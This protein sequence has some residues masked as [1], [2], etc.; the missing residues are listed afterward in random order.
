MDKRFD[1]AQMFLDFQQEAVN[2]FLT[3]IAAYDEQVAPAMEHQGYKLH[4]QDKRTVVF[5]FGEVTYYRNRWSKDGNYR[6]PVDEYLGLEKY[7]RYSNQLVYEIAKIAPCTSYR[8]VVDII[9][10]TYKLDITKNL[11]SKA[12]AEAGE[13]IK[14]REAYRFYEEKTQTKKIVAD[15][16]YTEGDGVLIKTFDKQTGH[17]ANMELTHFVVHTGSEQVGKNRFALENKKTFIGDNHHQVRQEVQD[18]VYNHFDITDKTVLVSNS[19]HGS[20][21]SPYIFR[22]LAKSLG[23]RRHEHFWDAYHLNQLVE[24]YFKPYPLELKELVFEGIAGHDREKVKLAVQ[25]VE[26]LITDDLELEVFGK[27]GQRLLRDFRY[28]KPAE[29]RGLPRAGIG[30]ME[31]QHRKITYRMKKQGRYWSRRG[32][33]TMS[34]LILLNYEGK[35]QDLFFGDWRDRYAYF[36]ELEQVPI[37]HYLKPQKGPT[38]FYL[39]GKCHA[40]RKL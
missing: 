21:Y 12:V 17:L 2:R 25:T 31:T 4:K 32:A 24:E 27:F 11:V 6:T 16:I 34:K 40:K 28:T 1:E 5:T 23:I 10:T 15:I 38:E 22:E 9:K 19:D 33:V 3:E 39:Q 30:I 26:S 7:S 14:E 13:L 35:L 8:K 20:G 37:S 29:L 36:R 18:Y